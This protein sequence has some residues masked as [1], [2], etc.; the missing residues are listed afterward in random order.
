MAKRERPLSPFMSYRWQY[1]MA[2]SI[3]H[4]I[5]GVF[6][7]IGLVAL[8]Y[9]LAELAAGPASYASAVTLLTS[10][11]AQL[12]LIAW[13]LSFF[14]HFLNG[15]RHLFWDAGYGFDLKTARTSGWTVFVAALVF[16]AVFWA[17]IAMRL[18][19]VA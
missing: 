7:S 12:A 15:I 6:L 13:S 17:L 4:R 14:Y 8:V 16:T 18:G 11:I 3:L 2:L 9:W 1:T 5:T 10:P 19:S